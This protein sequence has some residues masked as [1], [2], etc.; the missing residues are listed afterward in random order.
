MNAHNRPF[1]PL[2]VNFAALIALLAVTAGVASL[3]SG[4]WSTPV[5]LAVAVAKASLIFVFFMRLRSQAP[6]VRRFAL[7][8]FFFL[9]IL[10]VLTSADY[11]TRMLPV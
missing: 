1:R 8:G 6:L 3:P 9:A 7:V 4:W 5:A 2:V 11:F 10:L